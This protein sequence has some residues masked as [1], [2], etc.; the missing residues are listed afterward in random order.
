MKVLFLI[1]LPIFLLVSG[2]SSVRSKQLVGKT[3][4]DLT[5]S[6]GEVPLALI[7]GE[8]LD[9]DGDVISVI[10]TNAKEGELHCETVD[11]DD[12]DPAKLTLRKS[13]DHV[14]VNYPPDEDG[15]R[16]WFLMK[17]QGEMK[18]ILLRRPDTAIFRELIAKGKIKGVNDPE[19]KKDEDGN[20]FKNRR[21][22][23]VID[24]PSGE[25]V[26]KM[27][28]GEFGVVFDWQNPTVLRKKEAGA[29]ASDTAE[30]APVE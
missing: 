13:G 16:D 25:W 10:V 11:N 23:A 19:S 18:G 6:I 5:Q 24:D 4:V 17:I 9:L 29:E 12:D 26:E 15:E 8:W 2:C 27:I 3:K 7:A 28:A 14:F 20:E 1:A 30:P 21:P 22:G